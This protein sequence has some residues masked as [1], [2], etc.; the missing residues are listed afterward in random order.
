MTST[1]ARILSC[2]TRIILSSACGVCTGP[3]SLHR[4]SITHRNQVQLVANTFGLGP[5]PSALEQ[6][7]GWIAEKLRQFEMVQVEKTRT[8]AL[9]LLNQLNEAGAA[10]L[11]LK[12]T[13][14][15]L[16]L[17]N[18]EN[19]VKDLQLQRQEWKLRRKIEREKQAI[20]DI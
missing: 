13:E 12:R 5:V 9:R 16:N 8:I 15:D 11:R 19:N 6:Y 14:A 2:T 20:K 18:N 1:Y 17:I 10:L 7:Q 4:G 3:I